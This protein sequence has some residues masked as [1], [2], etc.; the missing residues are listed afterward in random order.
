MTRGYQV[1]PVNP[2]HSELL[3]QPCYPDITSIQAPIHVVNIFRR[4]DSVVPVVESAI[5][6]GGVRLIWMQDNVY[7]EA[8]A[9]LA[10]Q[11]GIA[12]VMD[13]CIYR[14]LQGY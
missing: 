6:K 14:F 2:G 4:S 11:A 3:D 13:D 7:N 12:V 9:E 8:A 1:Y 5:Q 10:Q